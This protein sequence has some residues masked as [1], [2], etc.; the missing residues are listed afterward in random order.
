MPADGQVIP[1][2][3]RANDPAFAHCRAVLDYWDML[4]DGR[5]MPLRSEVDP[6]GMTAALDHVFVL[7]RIAPGVARFR[8]AGLHLNDVLGF[9]VRGLPLTAL[10][11]S[12]QRRV[13]ADTVEAMFSTPETLELDL[14]RDG[15]GAAAPARMILAPLRSDL[16]DAS[17]AIGCLVA[18]GAQGEGMGSLSI[19]GALRTD[20][21]TGQT[22]GGLAAATGAEPIRAKAPDQ[23]ARPVHLRLVKD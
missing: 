17:R 18:P 5:V 15:D 20:L 10:F 21:L 14:V 8:L 16:G 4:R 3:Q 9:E 6:R 11:A 22:S 2:R 7:Q 13:L 1:L 12:D 23:P 19:R